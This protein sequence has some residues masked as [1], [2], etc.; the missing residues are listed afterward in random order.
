MCDRPLPWWNSR[1]VAGVR[2]SA[3]DAVVI[4]LSVPATWG[5]WCVFGPIAVVCPVV[6]GHFFLFCN[7][8]RV[9]LRAELLWALGFVLNVG[10]LFVADA[11]AWDRVA[12]IQAPMTITTIVTTMLREDYHGL[13]YSLLRG[14]PITGP[15]DEIDQGQ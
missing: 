5:L 4:V 7:V 3:R 1:R 10:V 6:L 9:G 2:M 13:G 14:G 12:M 8:F 11:F 15:R